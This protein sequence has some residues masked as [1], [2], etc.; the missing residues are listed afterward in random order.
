MKLPADSSLTPQAIPANT[1]NS[2]GVIGEVVSAVQR[3]CPDDDSHWQKAYQAATAGMKRIVIHLDAQADEYAWK[4]E[5][6]VGKVMETDGM[7]HL[8]WGAKIA[9]NTVQ[10]L[11]GGIVTPRRRFRAA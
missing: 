8:G 6:E 1:D 4:I 5:L 9:E 10:G 2:A 11:A 3:K 7:N